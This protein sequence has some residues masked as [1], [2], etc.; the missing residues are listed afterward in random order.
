MQSRVT[1]LFVEWKSPRYVLDILTEHPPTL[2]TASEGFEAFLAAQLGPVCVQRFREPALRQELESLLAAG[3][4]LEDGVFR[5]VHREAANDRGLADEFLGHFLS[6]M[7]RIGRLTLG[8]DL[9]R[10]L[11]TDDLVNSVA[12]SIW[13]DITKIE[14]QT[15]RKFLAFL[16]QRMR[17]K[18]ADRSR[19]MKAEK[20]R[21]DLHCE[22]DFNGAGV[23][24]QNQDGPY[25]LIANNEEHER[26]IL[27]VTRLPHR[28][29]DIVLR[30]FRGETHAQIALAL[31]LTPDAMRKALQRALEKARANI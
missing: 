18:A 21:E 11:D 10:F 30:H 8:D 29:R 12:G 23:P 22:I 6:A 5:L 31:D 25:T 2:H 16:G 4:T 26:M 3:Q 13:K 9:R 17:W 1:N 27:A 14:F 15:R 28:D 24:H 7:M 19:K 20:R